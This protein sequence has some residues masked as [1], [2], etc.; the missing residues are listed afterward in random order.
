[1]TLGGIE[2]NNGNQMFFCSYKSSPE[3]TEHK[4][5]I[6]FTLEE[7]KKFYS[8]LGKAIDGV[9]KQNAQ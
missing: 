3:L 7:A 9:E 6:W 1:M 5:Q 8:E 4:D 2:F